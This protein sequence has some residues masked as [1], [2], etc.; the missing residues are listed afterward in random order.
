MLNIELRKKAT[1][2]FEKDFFK[3]MCNAVFGKAMQNVRSLKDIKLVTTDAQR[4]KLVSQPNFHS[5]KWFSNNLLAIEMKKVKVKMNKPIYLGMSI[6]DISKK[7]MYEFWN[8]YLRPKYKENL[9]LCYMDTDSY[10]IFSVKTKDWYKDIS[11]DFE[12][13]FD[14]SNIQTNIPIKKGANK[15]F[16]CMWK[17]ELSGSPAKE[18]IGLRPK[19]YAYL[20][21]DGKIGKRAK[22][23]KKMCNKKRFNDYK[24]C[25]INSEKIMRCQQT[26][27]SE[28]HLVST[29]PIKK[30]ALSNNDDKRLIDFDRIATHAYGTN[31]GRTCKNKLLSK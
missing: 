24:D 7:P 12:K 21:D 13:R 8:D 3:M 10:I 17:D 30:I 2:D 5:S 4:N 11:N 1:T 15:K 26:F 25:L 22:G 20:I 18:F 19:F 6:L 14:T 28:I 23:V 16:L 9:R 29:I 27:K 31:V